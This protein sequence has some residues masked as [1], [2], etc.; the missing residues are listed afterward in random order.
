M[1][2]AFPG[3]ETDAVR[4][5]WI[6]HSPMAPADA[7]AAAREQLRSWLGGAGAVLAHS[8]ADAADGTQ[9]QRWQLDERGDDGTRTS[10]LTVH[11]PADAAGNAITWFWVESEFPAAGPGGSRL[12][13]PAGL[14]RLV[15]LVRGLLAAV[16]AYDSVA[17]LTD[18][19]LTIDVAGTDALID[20]LCEPDRRL[21]AVVA[22]AHPEIAF[23]DWQRVIGRVTRDLPGLAG[24]Y[25]MD[26]AATQAFGET[27]GATHAVW[28]GALR[29][30]MPDVDPAVADEALRH[31]VM[32]A[33]RIVADP[34]AAAAIVSALPR[35][36]AAEAPLPAAL[37]G[38]NRTLLTRAG[39]AVPAAAGTQVTLLAVERD[40]A[41]NL[42]REQ[43]ERANSLFAQRQ[44]ALAEITELEQR[45]L[46][47][48]SQVKILQER[49]ISTGGRDAAVRP[50]KG[51]AAPPG[52]FA[53]L[54]DWLET[55]LPRVAFTG[56][57]AEP[58]SLDQ[59]PES[60]TWV[61]SS[62]EVLRAMQSYASAK[63]LKKFTGDFKV[64]CA[65]PPQGAYGI[66]AGKVVRDE[67]E[68]VRNHGRWRRQR[69]FPVPAQID[70]AGRVFMGAHVRIGASAAGR[71][72]PRLYFHDATARFG[73][74]YVGY[75]GRHL[76]N[77]RS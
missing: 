35:R 19:P 52:T 5:R 39:D 2:E 25:L 47:L 1:G 69:E 23:T 41:L 15:G 42:A 62:W 3:A 21:P 7:F 66:P 43:E 38:V 24:I 18:S 45:V 61:R 75:L 76:S 16:P 73:M 50:I 72:N 29:T 65:A 74:M 37:A 77:T 28:D 14:A 36:L 46:Y 33:A 57:I 44:S 67:S 20:I 34:G 12:A 32:S 59:R 55:S 8:I 6:F 49:L 30:Y 51:P 64:W 31:R 60:S 10:S 53:E 17:R 40:L 58:L 11:A 27:I 48:E 22:S 13:G 4:D 63:A 71:I 56:D 70:P 9:T 54:L 26:A 68:T